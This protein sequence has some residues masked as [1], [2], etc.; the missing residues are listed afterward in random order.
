MNITIIGV[1]RIKENY[2]KMAVDEYTKR[3]GKYTNLK[4]IEVPDEK[5]YEN[6]SVTEQNIIKDKESKKVF[7]NIDKKDFVIALAID[8]NQLSSLEF[9]DFIQKN[10]LNSINNIKFVIGGSIG[11]S[12]EILNRANYRLSFSKF[13]FTHQ[14]M[15]VILLEQI[16]RCFKIINNEQYHK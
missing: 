14:L 15:R 12:D 2:L 10:M 7:A 8:G 6:M 11:L 9:S 5:T 16:Y 1:G 4:I 13:T 3:L